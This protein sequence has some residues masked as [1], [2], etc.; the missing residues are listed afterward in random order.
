ME[1][2][3]EIALPALESAMKLRAILNGRERELGLAPD[4]GGGP[5]LLDGEEIEADLVKIEPGLYS[6]LIAGRSMEV[7][8]EGGESAVWVDSDRHTVEIHDPRQWSR[9]ADAGSA[10][11]RRT[12]KTVMPGKIV[13]LLVARGDAVE[14]GQ[15]LLV[16]EAMKMQNEVKSPK[17]GVVQLIHVAAG[18]AVSAG[19]ALIDVE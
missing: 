15:G 6:V 19:Q 8:V 17:A 4:V 16:V 11:G 3:R 18:D 10:E 12:L 5:V 7:F 2:R 14:T 13:E 1:V 9:S